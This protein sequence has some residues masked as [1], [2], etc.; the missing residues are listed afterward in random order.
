ELAPKHHL[1]PFQARNFEGF[2]SREIPGVGSGADQRVTRRVAVLQDGAL[3]RG[4]IE[5]QVRRL[6]RDVH[7]LARQQVRP[8]PQPVVVLTLPA[9]RDVEGQAAG[10]GQDSAQ[11]PSA[12]H[13]AA[14]AFQVFA[15]GD[16]PDVTDDHA[17]ALVEY[18]RSALGVAPEARVLTD[19]AARVDG[20]AG[21]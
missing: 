12:Q 21:V 3:E 17:V 16:F 10:E 11:G 5:P 18:A 9:L 6:T 13:T 15:E 8:L 14:G 1:V 7:A 4:G 20:L 19:A 2:R